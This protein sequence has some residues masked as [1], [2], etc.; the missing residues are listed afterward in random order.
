MNAQFSGSTVFFADA[1][2]SGG[3]VTLDSN[4]SGG[5]I[6]FVSKVLQRHRRLRRC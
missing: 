3:R 6:S 4:F 1:E 2:F 5:R